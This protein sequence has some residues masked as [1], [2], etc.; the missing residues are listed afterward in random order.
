[1]F[2]IVFDGLFV[3]AGYFV[4]FLI[5]HCFSPIEFVGVFFWLHALFFH[6]ICFDA[7]SVL[8]QFA[9]ITVPS[10]SF[11]FCISGC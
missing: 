2:F 7:C 6:E 10:M 3:F 1:M 9:M 4:C 11:A 8:C 5:I